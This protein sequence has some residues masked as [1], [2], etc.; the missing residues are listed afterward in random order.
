MTE[1]G[2][3]HLWVEVWLEAS[4]LGRLAL[5]EAARVSLHLGLSITGTVYDDITGSGC[6]A[7]SQC[8]CKLHGHLYM[9]G[10]EITNDCEQW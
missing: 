2:S 7:V 9:P 10:Q 5:P 3:G 4:P 6:I 8:H 1:L